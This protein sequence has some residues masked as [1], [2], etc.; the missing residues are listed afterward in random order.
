VLTIAT[1][2]AVVVGADPDVKYEPVA[3]V[4]GAGV[5]VVPCEDAI[6]VE[7]KS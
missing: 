5:I 6:E 3:V 7:L 1:P 4:T 2:P